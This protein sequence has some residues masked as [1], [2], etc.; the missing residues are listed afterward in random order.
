MQIYFA[1]NAPSLGSDVFGGDSATA[2]YLPG[3][4]G[5][6]IFNANS[7]LNPVVLWNPQAQNDASFGVLS[8]Q[9]GF[10]ITGGSNPSSG[11]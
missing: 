3:T 10:N 11:F 1:G 7:Q 2:Y 8:N 6:A 9:F 5:W 4:T